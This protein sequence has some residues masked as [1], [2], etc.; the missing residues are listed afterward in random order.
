MYKL[1]IVDDER[2]IVESLYELFSAQTDPSYEILTSFYGDEALNLLHNQKIDIVLLDI[3]MPGLSGIQV[4]QQIMIN[5][6]MCRIIFL[7]AYANFDYIYQIRQMEHTAFI[8]KTESNNSIVEAVRNAALDIERENEVLQLEIQSQKDKIYLQYLLTCKIFNNFLQS[9]QLHIL[10]NELQKNPS[11]FPFHLNQPVQLLFLKIKWRQKGLHTDLHQLIVELT[12]NFQQ[13]LHNQFHISLVDIDECTLAAFL[14]PASSESA[15]SDIP[16]DIYMKECLNDRLSSYSESDE[17]PIFM[18]L[19]REA[20]SWA[21]LGKTFDMLQQYYT[22]ILLPCFPQYGRILTVGLSDLDVSPVYTD[23]SRTFYPKDIVQDLNLHLHDSNRTGIEDCIQKAGD[24]L[25]SLRS[26]HHLNGVRLYHEL[27]NIFLEYISQY[28]LE[29]KV[30]LKIGLYKLYNIN[31]FHS[32]QEL[33]NYYMQL[34]CILLNITQEENLSVKEQTLTQIKKYIHSNLNKNLTLNQ[35]ANY[36]NYNSSYLSRYFK[37]MTGE[38]ISQYIIKEKIDCAK[39]YLSS[40][41][42]SIQEI[43]EKLGFE[44]PQYFSIVFKKYTGVSPRSYRSS[45]TLHEIFPE[46]VSPDIQ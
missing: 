13:D 21:A 5:W 42:A 38:S 20:V 3:N 6:P 36:V 39:Q 35:L 18:I 29:E 43:S 34:A 25:D 1:L 22:S 23:N 7:T 15:S 9:R 32:W 44:T 31:Q 30:A 14:Q 45:D 4:A 17:C 12:L 46:S 37:Q 33:T 19:L 24:Y 2:Y 10:L 27:S 26:M 28:H 40:S 41:N 16:S 11:C 8:L